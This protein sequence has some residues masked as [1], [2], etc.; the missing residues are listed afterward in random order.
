[1]PVTAAPHDQRDAASRPRLLVSLHD[2]SPVT[3][4]ACR[5][6]VDL[7]AGAGLPTSALT[8]LVVPLHDDRVALD[9]DPDTLAFVRD[10]AEGGATLV[11]HGLTHRMT[12]SPRT[13]ARWLAARFFARGEGELAGTD[14]ADTA[15][16]LDAADAIFARAGLADHVYGFVPPAWLLSPA[17]AAVV[18][19]RGLP[20][21]ECFSGIARGNSLLARRLIGWGSLTE[22]DARATAAWAWLQRHRPPADTRLA[23]HPPDVRRATT[24]RSLEATLAA[25]LRTHEPVSYRTYLDAVHES[26]RGGVGAAGG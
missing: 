21:H 4:D 15:R 23:V 13:P 26:P 16:R 8:V 17:A 19:E 18:A 5:D 2:V 14:A 1:M 9:D 24:R 22:V 7:L 3:V 11:A 20:F 6:A 25:L 12:R 10:L